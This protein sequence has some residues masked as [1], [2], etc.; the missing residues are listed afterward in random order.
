MISNDFNWK[1]VEILDVER[2]FKKRLIFEMINIKCQK[3]SIN[4][5]TDNEV[6]DHA[7]SFCFNIA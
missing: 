3:N 1:N 2:N 4:L 5:Q 7:Y 6:L